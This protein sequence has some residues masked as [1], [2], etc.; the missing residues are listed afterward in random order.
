MPHGGPGIFASPSALEG[1]RKHVTVLFADRKGSMEIV[2]HRDQEEA[3]ALVDP[4]LEYMIQAKLH[5]TQTW[6]L[7]PLGLLFRR[8]GSTAG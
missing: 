3:H 4:V 5:G 7:P 6:R 8:T 2:A 1:E